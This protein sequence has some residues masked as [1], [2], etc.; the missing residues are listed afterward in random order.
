[1]ENLCKG[2]GFSYLAHI[3]ERFPLQTRAKTTVSVDKKHKKK[4]REQKITVRAKRF[5]NN[6]DCGKRGEFSSTER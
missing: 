2:K 6:Y 5:L 3:L 4:L 1:M